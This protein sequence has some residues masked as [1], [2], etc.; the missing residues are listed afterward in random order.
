[1]RVDDMKTKH[2]YFELFFRKDTMCSQVALESGS[3]N[4]SMLC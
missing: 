4:E 1:M 2:K 3:L